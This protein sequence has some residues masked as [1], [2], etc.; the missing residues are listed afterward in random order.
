VCRASLI[1]FLSDH[2]SLNHELALA[3]LGRREVVR[4]G[5]LFQSRGLSVLPGVRS[6]RLVLHILR[7]P[8][9]TIHQSSFLLR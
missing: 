5:P 3:A 4:T 2:A 1:L 7:D 9:S 8:P 6:H